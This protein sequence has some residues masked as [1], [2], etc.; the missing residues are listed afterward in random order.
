LM[1]R[2]QEEQLSVGRFQRNMYVCAVGGDSTR[3]RKPEGFVSNIGVL[4]KYGD[5]YDMSVD[6]CKLNTTKMMPSSASVN[7]PKSRTKREKH[8]TDKDRQKNS[9]QKGK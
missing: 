7:V 2:W 9:I 6:T 1:R 5:E 3:W 4:V 8:A